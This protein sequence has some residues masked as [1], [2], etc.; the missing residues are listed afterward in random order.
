MINTLTSLSTKL[1]AS[2]DA[3]LCKKGKTVL[4]GKQ[5]TRAKSF[6]QADLPGE[7]DTKKPGPTYESKHSFPLAHSAIVKLLQ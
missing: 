3:N 7:C 4:E 6:K 2:E 5:N 1:R